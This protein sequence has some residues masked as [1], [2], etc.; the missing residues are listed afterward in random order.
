MDLL[1][2][3]FQQDLTDP[4]TVIA[5]QT[6]LGDGEIVLHLPLQGGAHV[7]NVQEVGKFHDLLDVQQAPVCG[8]I[9]AHPGESRR[10][11]RCG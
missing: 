7:L 9:L 11:A 8:V 6:L 2:V 3:A 5:R 4:G 1:A 10:P